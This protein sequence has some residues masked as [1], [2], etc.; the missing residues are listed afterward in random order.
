MYYHPA[1]FPGNSATKH[2]KTE[3]E[4][5]REAKRKFT[6]DSISEEATVP[7]FN[8]R[9]AHSDEY[10]GVISSISLSA[11]ISI[12]IVC[13]TGDVIRDGSRA[14][15]AS[16]LVLSISHRDTAYQPGGKEYP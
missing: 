7:F 16:L 11:L 4:R 5:E 2:Y 9:P 10:Y 15:A 12:R 6:K 1:W 14:L 8:S 13:S 3:R